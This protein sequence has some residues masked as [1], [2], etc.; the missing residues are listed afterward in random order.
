M[1]EYHSYIVTTKFT[2]KAI[3]GD[4]TLPVGTVLF[5]SNGFILCPQG[6]ICAVTSQNAYD[7]FAQN[8]DGKG[9]ER[10]ILIHDIL[11]RLKKLKKQK[12]RDEIIWNKIWNDALCLKYKRIEYADHWLWNYDFYNA[13]I[14]DLKYI[15]KLVM[16]GDNDV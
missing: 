4:I 2:H 10:G 13:P 3:C 16:K 8:D 5:A 12:E 15:Q 6:R 14:K 7:F 1:K 9:K 11:R